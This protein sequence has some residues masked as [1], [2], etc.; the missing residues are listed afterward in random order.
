M[1]WEV[2]ML[3]C[4]SCNG[5]GRR[6]LRFRQW[7]KSVNMHDVD[8]IKGDVSNMDEATT[9]SDG[10]ELAAL[11]NCQDLLFDMLNIRRSC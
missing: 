11:A 6:C 2:D 8:C 1:K 10:N 4:D 3:K 5:N 7:H 9:S